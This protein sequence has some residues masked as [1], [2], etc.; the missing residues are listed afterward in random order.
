[1]S[2]TDD[3]IKKF[4]L[5]SA[6]GGNLFGDEVQDMRAGG[7]DVLRVDAYNAV[8]QAAGGYHLKPDISIT[9]PQNGATVLVNPG[10]CSAQVTAQAADVQDGQWPL[11][12]YGNPGPTPI[13]FSS[14]VKP[15]SG[16]FVSD[17]GLGFAPGEGL[18]HVTA[19]VTNSSG[20]SN[21]ATIAVTFK[22][23]HVTPSPVI[24]WPPRNTTVPYGIYTVTGYAKST[25]PGV[26]G[27]FDCNRLVFDGNVPAVPVP[28]SNGLCQAQVTLNAPSQVVTL[29]A[30]DIFGDKGTA[31][32]TVTVTG[33]TQGQLAVQILNPVNGAYVRISN[34]S[35]PIGLSGNASP[36]FQNSKPSY[37]WWW[38]YTA[39]GP[40]THKQIASG[41]NSSA[42][43]NAQASGLCQ[44]S[45]PQDV[46]IEL[47]VF[48]VSPKSQ[49]AYGSATSR[50]TLTCQSI[51]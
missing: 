34:S 45:T 15:Y 35:S 23:P 27:N 3:D 32:V 46:T 14:D 1:V 40:G 43:W 10:A 47:D 30:T 49:T 42:T 19:T 39:K 5:G 12:N 48:D 38:Y 37:T 4:L 7:I 22:Y 26:F 41:V 50:I 16:G 44:V 33:Q 2:L 11:K 36:L 6:R 8:V 24:T 21:S 51:F 25:D 13:V 20:I 9:S 31:S 28:N 29:S 17:C 18:Q